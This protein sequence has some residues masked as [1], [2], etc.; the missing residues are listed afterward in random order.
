MSKKKQPATS[1]KAVSRAA[2]NAKP[3]A[4]KTSGPAIPPRLTK[5]GPVPVAVSH[6][7]P[8]PQHPYYHLR[9][10]F[11]LDG[12][13]SYR[14]KRVRVNGQRVRDF[15]LFHGFRFQKDQVLKPGGHSELV[16]RW[17]WKPR[18]EGA[19]EVSAEGGPKGDKPLTLKS[20]LQAPPF[21]GYWDPG[22][23]FYASLVLTEL[24]GLDR[25]DEPVHTNLAVYADRIQDPKREL[26]VVAVDPVSGAH[27]E[28]PCQVHEVKHYK[29]EGVA[30]GDEYQPTTTFQLCFFADVPADSSRVYLAFYGN[31][32][33]KAPAY[34]DGLS[35]NGKAPGYVIDNPYYTVLLH[36]KS[37][38]IDEIHM[39]MGVGA[40]F[41]HHLETN[42]AL[43]WNPCFYAPPKPWLHASDWDPPPEHS[44]LIGPVFISTQRSGHVEPYKEE[45]H[46]S[47]TYRFYARTPWIFFSTK[48]EVRKDI[49]AKA[50]RNGEIVLDRKLVDEFAWRQADGGVGTMMI[51]DGPKHPRHAKVLP[52]DTP[53]VCFFN[54]KRRCGLGVV[55]FKTADFRADGGLAKYFNRYRYMQWSKWV[56]TCR[57]F[58]YTF[59]TMNQARLVPVTAGNLYYEEMAL[60][61]LVVRPEAES[62][63]QLELLYAKMT[64]PLDVQ[65]VEDTDPRAPEGWVSPV[66]VEE[67][68]EFEEE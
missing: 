40:K 62:F 15:E 59:S 2:V 51:T 56:Y 24:A 33:A 18:E 17:D 58:V 49:A 38:S 67:F 9:L 21:G 29:A 50:L 19:V 45:S 64:N 61:P 14:I 41:Y 1:S 16:V 47:V 5:P 42:G 35:L 3:T 6:G 28:V 63:E 26:R 30:I 68:D 53:W 10:T 57:P 60:M 4:K 39:K 44:V 31:P 65:V 27:R 37:G 7:F 23:K 13:D 22:W 32:K 36:S 20:R 48:L 11:S 12:G 43:H 8:T 55:S 52:V 34:N 46:M 25:F 66:L 54:R